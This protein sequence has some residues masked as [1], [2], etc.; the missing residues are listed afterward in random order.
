M[1]TLVPSFRTGAN[2]AGT[3]L[4]V[5]IASALTAAQ[6]L[7]LWGLAR[8]L[9]FRRPA[10]RNARRICVHRVGTI[11]D[12]TC[13]IPALWSIREANPDASLTLLTA[14]GGQDLPGARDLL[15][16]V[17]WIDE[18]LEYGP[19]RVRTVS[20]IRSLATDLRSRRFDLWVE[21]PESATGAG[22]QIRKMLFAR[23]CGPGDGLGWHV[24][25]VN[26]FP[27]AQCRSCRW[28]TEVDRLSEILAA[29]GIPTR[30]I[31]FPLEL[32]KDEVRTVKSQLGSGGEERRPLLGICPA[33][34]RIDEGWP[35]ERFAALGTRWIE[36]FA[37]GVVFVGGEADRRRG[38]DIATRIEGPT[39]NLCGRLT[40]RESAIL[41]RC[42]RVLA[43]HDTGPM[44]LAA[45]VETPCVALFPGRDYPGKWKPWGDIH[46]VFRSTDY[47]RSCFLSQ[48]RASDECLLRVGVDEAWA[49][50][51]WIA[52]EGKTRAPRSRGKI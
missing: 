24:A 31:R 9:G 22:R 27:A 30:E 17:S 36:H 8:S 1:T 44:H 28:P 16:P 19:E 26:L 21:L 41:L 51:R 13:A 42:C 3:R 35:A 48:C 47:C 40:V 52:E 45:A 50:V 4:R 29:E 12:I 39:V 5:S 43:T 18:I 20:G 15:A 10:Q 32:G 38:H 37:G 23:V 14:R 11:G 33:G 7:A 25:S 49:A 46:E 2:G 6:N 34:K